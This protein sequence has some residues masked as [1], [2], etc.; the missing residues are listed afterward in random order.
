MNTAAGFMEKISQWLTFPSIPW[1]QFRP[2]WLEL[3]DMVAPWDRIFPLTD[4]LTI[5]GLILAVFGALMIF[6]TVVL[7]KSFIPFS[8]GK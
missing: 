4:V 8:G 7:I 6:Y 1:A 2:K 5:M 3:I